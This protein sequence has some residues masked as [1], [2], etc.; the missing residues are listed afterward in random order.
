MR[1]LV[2]CSP[3]TP[4]TVLSLKEMGLA[5]KSSRS[6]WELN[7][8][9]EDLLGVSLCGPSH[10]QYVRLSL[11]GNRNCVHLAWIGLDRQIIA[12]RLVH[13]VHPLRSYTRQHKISRESWHILTGIWMPCWQWVCNGHGSY[14]N[15]RWHLGAL[16]WSQVIEPWGEKVQK[17]RCCWSLL[18]LDLRRNCQDLRRLS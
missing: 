13:L 15:R 3:F 10:S 18:G 2:Y 14:Q 7:G 9:K 4:C 12:K 16:S 6:W 11:V 1:N 5:I 8:G 17:E